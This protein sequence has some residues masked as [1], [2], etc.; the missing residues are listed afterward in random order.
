MSADVVSTGVDRGTFRA[1]IARERGGVVTG[2]AP[3]GTPTYAR[4]Q[5]GDFSQR[6]GS[7]VSGVYEFEAGDK[8]ELQGLYEGQ[9]TSTVQFNLVGARSGISIV[10][11]GAGPEGPQGI[12]GPGGGAQLSDD[13]PRSVS[14]GANSEGTAADASRRDHHHHVVPASTTQAGVI[15]IATALEVEAGVENDKAVTPESLQTTYLDRLSDSTPEDVGTG[16]VGNSARAAR[17]DHAHGGGTGGAALSDDDPADVGT[18][19][20]GTGTE[21]SRDDH[22][23]GGGTG[24]GVTLSDD[25]PRSVSTGANSEGTATDASRRDHHHQ[26]VAATHTVQGIVELA[27]GVETI[28]GT[29]TTRATTPFDVDAAL[30]DRA[31]DDTPVN[32]AA[33]A[34]GAGTDFARDD[35]DHGIDVSGG[36]GDGTV[37]NGNGA[38]AGNS[39]ENG[40]TYRD[41]ESGAWYKKASGAWSAA[42]YTPDEVPAAATTVSPAI[43]GRP[44]AVGTDETYARRGHQHFGIGPGTVTPEPITGTAAVGG[45]VTESGV[46]VH[47]GAYQNHGHA[48]GID[49]TLQR[50]SSDQLGVNVTDVTEH[51]QE[52]IR[53]FT[54]GD[55]FSTT[56]HATKGVVYST[57][58]F[59]KSISHLYMSWSNPDGHDLHLGLYRLDKTNGEIL[60][61][62]FFGA[63]GTGNPGADG[64]ELH[65]PGI[66]QLNIPPGIDLGICLSR[67]GGGALPVNIL[68]GPASAD[69]PDVSYGNAESDFTFRHNTLLNVSEPSVGQSLV[70]GAAGEPWGNIQIFYRVAIDHASLVGDGNV[71][72]DHISSGS[73]TDGQVITADGS[74]N[75]AWEDA[76]AG[77]GGAGSDPET[78]FDNHPTFVEIGTLASNITSTI[79]SITLAAVPTET[80]AVTDF[81]LIEN[82]VIDISVVNGAV[83]SGSRGARGTLESVHLAGTPVYLLTTTNG[84]LGR[85]LTTRTWAYGS[86]HQNAFDLGKALAEVDDGQQCIIEVEYD[87]TDTRRYGAITVGAETLREL[88]SL[89]RTVHGQHP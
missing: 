2:L 79:T 54:D 36:A 45:S 76:A 58:N 1:R 8:I 33:A 81:L 62:L 26:V 57:S 29:N 39:G 13:D 88:R 23:H 31:S 82:E 40:D 28:A 30:T 15:E 68:H 67:A 89:A 43:E 35:H 34:A 84:G 56:P 72:V 64:E 32:T 24:G 37:L 20:A 6:L 44:A 27:T 48:L 74:G 3:E 47:R 51:L 49:N 60:E 52:N 10:S 41:D 73:A 17:G 42:L 83:I 9:G 38:P 55:T 80:V 11:V 25:D 12:P 85:T 53:Y 59:R 18:T 14:T 46:Q 16:D 5:Y 21:S 63:S 22:V 70:T 19:A 66:N 50:D 75:S 65:F 71:N 77:G 69:S 61:V 4:N 86:S 7:A 87:A 78:L